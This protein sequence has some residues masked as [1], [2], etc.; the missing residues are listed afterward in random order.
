MVYFKTLSC[1]HYPVGN[2]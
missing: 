1:S 2:S